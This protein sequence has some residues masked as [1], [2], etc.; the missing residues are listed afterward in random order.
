MQGEEILILAS[1][2]ITLKPQFYKFS[3]QVGVGGANHLHFKESELKI[4]LGRKTEEAP[5]S[6]PLGGRGEG[7]AI[8]VKMT[9]ISACFSM[10]YDDTIPCRNH[11]VILHREL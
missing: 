2:N 6:S 11:G 8:I 9:Y 10:G 5:R 7:P 3:R 4:L 1:R